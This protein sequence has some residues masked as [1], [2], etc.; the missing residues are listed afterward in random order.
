MNDLQIFKLLQAIGRLCSLPAHSYIVAKGLG[1]DDQMAE[2]LQQIAELANR[3]THLEIRERSLGQL[4]FEV[5]R[6]LAL[7]PYPVP[8]DEPMD[9]DVAV[10]L[11]E[12]AKLASLSAQRG[13]SD[14]DGPNQA[15]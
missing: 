14:H 4:L 5:V 10:H 2:R 11:G 15:G 1:L 6:D 13:C 12:I 9:P 8:S 3:H 7:L